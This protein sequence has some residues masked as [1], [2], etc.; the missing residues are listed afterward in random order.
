MREVA[1]G[2]GGRMWAR[3]ELRRRWR[4]LLALGLLA[5]ITAGLAS[6][7]VAGARRTDAAWDRL[8]ADSLASDAIV[9]ASQ[10][11]IA[12]PDWDPIVALPYVD[13]A[14]AFSFAD[15]IVVDMSTGSQH[16]GEHAGLVVSQYGD[17]LT[18]VDRPRIIDGR[19]P[20]PD[21]PTEIVVEGASEATDPGI[22]RFEVGDEFTIR[23]FTSDQGLTSSGTPDGPEVTFTVV[24]IAE[25]PLTLAAI[26]ALAGSPLAGPAFREAYPETIAGFSNLFVR[27]HDPAG[28]LRR[29]ES[30]VARLFP[31]RGV[32]VTDLHTAAKRVTNGTDLEG[33]GLRLFALAVAAAGTVIVGQ[34]LTRS[35]RAASGDLPALAAVGLDRAGG[36]GALALPHLLSAAT[37]AVVSVVLAVALSPRFPIGLGRRVDPDVGV[38]LDALVVLGGAAVIA[39]LLTAAVLLTAWRAAGPSGT[40]TADRR[41]GIVSGLQALGARVTMAFGASLALEPGRGSRALPTRSAIA[42]AVVGVVGVAGALVFLGGLDDAASNP[43]R[44]GA[45]WDLEAGFTGFEPDAAFEALPGTLAEDPDV[46]GVT[47][48]GRM[49]GTLDDLAMPIYAIEPVSGAPLSFVTLSGRAPADSGEVV[50]GPDTAADLD[51]VVG[52]DVELG[53]GVP[54]RV[55]GLGLLP[56]TPHSSF[57]QGVWVVP[58][59]IGSAIPTAL[60]ETVAEAYGVDLTDEEAFESLFYLSGFLGATV[61]D[62]VDPEAVAGRVAGAAG[63]TVFITPP[64]PPADQIAMRNVRSLP[65]LF[66]VFA[67]LV[68]LGALLHVTSSVLR[69]RGA[70]LAILR[71]LGLTPFQTGTCL[72][73]QATL[74]A[75]IG[76]IVGIPLGVAIGRGTW[77]LVAEHIP[78]VQ[79]TAVA[80][81]PLLLL[82]PAAIIAANVVTLRPAWRTSRL[83]AADALR[84]D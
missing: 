49:V 83:S 55:V 10:A 64:S 75:V 36:T 63:D 62:G 71:T 4:S 21:D 38:H 65:I 8:R 15:G 48:V 29:L 47:R 84:A 59:D 80:A 52:D 37:A 30:D 42:G 11:G 44:F 33:T 56:T 79:V 18:E 14:G 1:G 28:D 68:A 3:A 69:Q 76:L 32:P 7:A 66:A 43:E 53:D 34:A 58:D 81:V 25:S 70:D 50:L 22:P 19:L 67:P 12:D 74:L 17:W 2:A 5:G 13:A 27:L 73:W 54:F 77:Q 41:S 35:V 72:V 78:I 51:V 60:R 6:A 61:R 26:P 82:L 40:R 16:D 46:T 39:A 31:D 20:D 45:A 57:D 23:F 9:F 24:G